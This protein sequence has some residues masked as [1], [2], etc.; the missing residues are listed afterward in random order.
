MN[1]S[2]KGGEISDKWFSMMP[3]SVLVLVIGGAIMIAKE[4]L[5]LVLVIIIVSNGDSNNKRI[6]KKSVGNET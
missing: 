2:D 1:D 5:S 3:T 4:M 6:N